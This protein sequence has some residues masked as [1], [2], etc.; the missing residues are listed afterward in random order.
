MTLAPEHIP[1]AT[2]HA[3]R[4]SIG[5]TF[6]YGVDYVLIDPEHRGG[7]WLFS[8]NARNLS[9]VRD[10]DHGGPLDHGRGADWAR[11]ALAAHGF[12]VPAGD[13]DRRLLLLT[14]PAFL[15]YSFNPVSFW[16]AFENDT[17]RAVIAEVSTPF[18]DRHSYLCHNAGFSPITRFDR[19][20]AP[21]HLHVSPFQDVAGNYE[22]AFDIRPDRIAIRIT[23]RN[24]DEGLIATLTG[25]RRPLTSRGIVAATFRR[26]LGAMRT[27]ALIYW[28][29]LVLKL[30][31][32]RYRPRPEPPAKEIT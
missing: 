13:P 15:G 3:R 11:E 23:H 9:A 6:R 17:L 28:Q 12:A 5:N 1:G 18:H 21:K 26:P 14:Q 7:P 27:I 25:P 4:G 16:L 19:I 32:A 29:A 20:T 24:G 10:R 2:T 22:F 31:G 30:K 8:R